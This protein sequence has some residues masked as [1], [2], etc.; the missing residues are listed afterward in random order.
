MIYY[1]PYSYLWIKSM[2]KLRNAWGWAWWNSEFSFP[3]RSNRYDT[4]MEFVTHNRRVSFKHTNPFANNHVSDAVAVR[5]SW[6]ISSIEV[7][8][9]ITL[10]HWEKRCFEFRSEPKMRGVYIFLIDPLLRLLFN[11]CLLFFW[12]LSLRSLRFS[13]APKTNYLTRFINVTRRRGQYADFRKD[14]YG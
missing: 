8:R 7:L 9:L 4:T 11:T 10:N 12:L 13:P 1:I 3:F 2:M 14:S 6:S 5:A